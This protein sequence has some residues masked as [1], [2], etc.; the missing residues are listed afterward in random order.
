MPAKASF[1]ELR[2]RIPMA[3]NKNAAG[4][5][6]T[7]ASPPRAFRGLLH[8]GLKIDIMAMMPQGTNESQNPAWPGLNPCLATTTDAL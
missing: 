5:V 4:V 3:L 1:Q 8:P 7:M 6:V 2:R